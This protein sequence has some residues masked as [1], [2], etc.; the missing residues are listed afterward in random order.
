M[1]FSH[2]H[3]Y[4]YYT[5][6]VIMG[7]LHSMKGYSTF[8]HLLLLSFFFVVVLYAN[9]ERVWK[10]SAIM[11]MAGGMWQVVNGKGNHLTFAKA[12]LIEPS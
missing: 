8:L 1:A 10:L 12:E 6:G 2:K 9:D 5:M 7:V 4:L 3:N 11:L